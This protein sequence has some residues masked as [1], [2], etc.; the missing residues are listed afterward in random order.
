MFQ[1]LVIQLDFHGNGR[2]SPE[3]QLTATLIETCLYFIIISEY[4]QLSWIQTTR[5]FTGRDQTL[6]TFHALFEI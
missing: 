5:K 3:G 2:K 1:H 4:R 6:E